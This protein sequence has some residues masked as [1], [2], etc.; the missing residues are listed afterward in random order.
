MDAR[1]AV[2][3]LP[4]WVCDLHVRLHLWW[5]SLQAVVRH[6]RVVLQRRKEWR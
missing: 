1:V 6:V 2:E 5:R 4:M 3:R